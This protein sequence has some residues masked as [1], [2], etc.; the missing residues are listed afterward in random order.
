MHTY[1]CIINR[2]IDGDTINIDIDLGFDMWL[3]NEN[4]R[5]FGVD[6]P[7]S[8]STDLVEKK[9][10]LYTTQ[11]VENL[12]PV[13]SEQIFKS[14]EFNSGKYGR[15]LGDFIIHENDVG[16]LVEYLL[17]NEL[18]VEYNGENK[19]ELKVFHEINR[20]SLIE[21]GKVK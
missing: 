8:R 18:A 7:E 1:K 13:G 9:F 15:I 20:K 12:L 3:R 19:D 10:G 21:Q 14:E 11:E 4:V 6:A 16:S 2:V 17:Y 5:L